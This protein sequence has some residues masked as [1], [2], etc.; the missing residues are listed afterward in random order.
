MRGVHDRI[1]KLVQL[2]EAQHP[3]TTGGAVVDELVP[4]QPHLEAV[5][6]LRLADAVALDE[7]VREEVRQMLDL[8]RFLG[9][10]A[11]KAL[12]LGDEVVNVYV[13]THDDQVF[14]LGI[15]DAGA[16]G[17]ALVDTAECDTRK[18]VLLVVPIGP[19][20]DFLDGKVVD[21][22]RRLRVDFD[23][24]FLVLGAAF[25]LGRLK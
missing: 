3:A 18:G 5:E 10:P 8:H 6:L 25:Q 7:V 16:L 4:R 20:V 21:D 22:V 19:A 1:D 17:I 2:G 11:I 23:N 13:A 15:D 14:G 9:G 24:R 12:G